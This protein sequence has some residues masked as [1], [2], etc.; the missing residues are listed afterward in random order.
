[1]LSSRTYFTKT[2]KLKMLALK[3]TQMSRNLF[4]TRSHLKGELPKWTKFTPC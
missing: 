4:K 2:K 1:M 3:S